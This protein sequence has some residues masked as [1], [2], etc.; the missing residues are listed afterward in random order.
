MHRH[1]FQY[2][3]TFYN[4]QSRNIQFELR[5]IHTQI[6]QADTKNIHIVCSLRFD[7]LSIW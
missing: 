6:H 3:H 1:L 5:K 2:G 4:I 7:G